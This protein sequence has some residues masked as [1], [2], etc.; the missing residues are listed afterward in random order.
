MPTRTSHGY[1]LEFDDLSI[2]ADSASTVSYNGGVG[3]T[4]EKILGNIG[5]L[6]ELAILRV[7][8]RRFGKGPNALVG[9]MLCIDDWDVRRCQH[10][11][12]VHGVFQPYHPL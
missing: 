1:S 8:E 12:C 9:R 6:L 4:V 10:P 7:A 11:S 5:K 3:R 2:V